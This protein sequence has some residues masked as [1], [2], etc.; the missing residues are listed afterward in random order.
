MNCKMKFIE[1]NLLD[2]YHVILGY[3]NDHVDHD[4]CYDDYRP[5][6]LLERPFRLLD[7]YVNSN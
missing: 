3:P 4:Y 5:F 7:F 6:D 1:L 2:C